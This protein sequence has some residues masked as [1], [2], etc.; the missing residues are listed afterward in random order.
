MD[1]EVAY[2]KYQE[3]RYSPYTEWED[4]IIDWLRAQG[5]NTSIATDPFSFICGYKAGADDLCKR[6]KKLEAVNKQ[7]LEAL[8]EVFEIG[9]PEKDEKIRAATKAGEELGDEVSLDDEGRLVHCNRC[10]GAHPLIYVTNCYGEQTTDI[11]TIRC[12]GESY[13]VVGNGRF[14]TGHYFEE[15]IS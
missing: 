13:M 8:L 12:N 6:V 1:K 10:G 4:S 7:M 11:G 9:V 15:D 2:K 5:E 3:W 14:Y